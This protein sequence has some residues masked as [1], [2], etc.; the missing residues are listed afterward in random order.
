MSD[1]TSTQ[2]NMKV[3]HNMVYYKL[4]YDTFR[5][6]LGAAWTITGSYP[7]YTA[8]S[9]TQPPRP[10]FANG[11]GSFGYEFRSLKPEQIAEL[12]P[13]YTVEYVTMGK[14]IIWSIHSTWSALKN[15]SLPYGVSPDLQTAQIDAERYLARMG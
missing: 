12:M 9:R 10:V 8:F 7:F 11:D 2:P 13:K 1:T 3:A 5:A 6:E 4:R 15:E 14:A